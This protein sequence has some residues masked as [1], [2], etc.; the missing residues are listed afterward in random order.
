MADPVTR[1]F[2]DGVVREFDRFQKWNEDLEKRQRS[3]EIKIAIMW[4]LW[5]A[6]GTGLGWLIAKL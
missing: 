5:C 3:S 2:A 1:D 4:F 6:V